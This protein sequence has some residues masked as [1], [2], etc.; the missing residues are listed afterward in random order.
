MAYLI[1]SN[2]FIQPKNEYYGFDICPGYWDWLEQQNKLGVIYSID[3]IASELTSGNDDLATWAKQKDVSFFLPTDDAALASMTQVTDWVVNNGFSS[4]VVT[5][6][7]GGADPFLIAFALA[8][9]HTVVSHERLV[10]GEK[11]KIKIPAVCISLNVD[12]ISIFELLRRTGAQL[13]LRH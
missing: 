13:I 12:C 7:M 11:K 4:H 5:P 10:V 6:F 3:K 8:H 9:R 2:C 1:D